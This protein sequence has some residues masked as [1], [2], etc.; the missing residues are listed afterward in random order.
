MSLRDVRSVQLLM[1]YA[2]WRSLFLAPDMHIAHHQYV[3]DA[4]QL[5]TLEQ[6]SSTS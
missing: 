1:K 5:N 6:G 2:L 4:L 3:S